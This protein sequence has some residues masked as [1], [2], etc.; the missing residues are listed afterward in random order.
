VPLVVRTWNLF[1]G[2]ADPPE[3]RAF[4][5]EMVELVT[6]DGPDVVCLQEVPLWAFAELERWSGMRAVTGVARPPRLRSAR[7][8]RL[9]TELHHGL[10]RSALTGEGAAILAA[11][12]LNVESPRRVVVGERPLRRIALSARVED[13]LVVDFHVNASAAELARA[14]AIA[15]GASRAILAGDAN[16]RPPYDLEGWSEPLAGSIDQILVRGLEAPA[17]P[18]AWPRE[19]RMVGDRVLSDHAPVELR[20]G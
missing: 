2:N 6:A 15:D 20:L 13:V 9:V 12:Q 3:R 4:L 10:L 8:G 1:H 16:L 18:E 7:L 14:A 5:R 19:R 17:P 11:R